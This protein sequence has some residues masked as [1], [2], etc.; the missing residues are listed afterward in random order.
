M[1]FK[2][3]N[4]LFFILILSILLSGCHYSFTGASVPSH[5]HTIAI[6]LFKDNS[7]SGEPDLNSNFTFQTIQYFIDDNNLQVTE[8]QAADAT[9]TCTITGFSDI[10]ASIT[11]NE[12]ISL[13]RVTLTV[14][15]IYRDL[16]MKKTVWQQNFSNYEDYENKGDILQNRR[17]AI[18]E[19]IKKISDDILL[20]VV[21]NW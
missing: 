5:L 14:K 15:A 8:K 12:Q 20:A 4:T 11:G 1:K 17:D 13:R 18:D 19:A 10:T 21:A 9:L 7:G 16:V 6:P 2:K 3:F